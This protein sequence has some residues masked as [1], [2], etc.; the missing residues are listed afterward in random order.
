MSKV[1]VP[2]N[3]NDIVYT[4]DAL[5]KKI[6]DYFQPTGKCLEPCLGGGAFYHALNGRPGVS[7]SWCELAQGVDFFQ[8][9]EKVD[10]II[11]NPPW[12]KFRAFLKHSMSL[13]D[14]IVFLVTLN[15]FQ[16]KARLRDM[17]EAGFW[18]TD[19][20]LLDTPKEFPQ[21]GFQ[22]AAVRVGRSDGGLFSMRYA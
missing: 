16:T 9:T 6:V 17:K 18:F 14:N 1:L 15:H 5:A 22:L 20:L 7:V 4:P 12:S 19:V 8:H 3:G 10:W 13:A 2:Q 21:S 11:T